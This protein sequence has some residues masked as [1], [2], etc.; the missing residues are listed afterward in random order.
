[1]LMESPRR[2]GNRLHQDRYSTG[3][4]WSCD[5]TGSAFLQSTPVWGKYPYKRW[6]TSIAPM[7]ASTR[8]Y[9]IFRLLLPTRVTPKD[10]GF[11]LIAQ[12]H[13][14]EVSAGFIIAKSPHV[15]AWNRQASQTAFSAASSSACILVTRQYGCHWCGFIIS[16]PETFSCSNYST[17]CTTSWFS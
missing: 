8:A 12:V 5:G 14:Q 17:S 4:E 7:F 16:R 3:E 10:P 2:H 9:K 15:H 11:F 1:M 6:N 13:S